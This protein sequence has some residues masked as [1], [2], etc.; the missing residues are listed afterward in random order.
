MGTDELGKETDSDAHIV[1]QEGGL[2]LQA[3]LVA[4]PPSYSYSSCI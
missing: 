4:P 2:A 1:C 3:Y